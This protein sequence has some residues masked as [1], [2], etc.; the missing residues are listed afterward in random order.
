MLRWEDSVKRDV[1]KVGEEEDWK[2]KT[3]EGW[4]RQSDEEVTS[5]G[6]HLTSDKGKKRKRE[7]IGV[8]CP[9]SVIY[10]IPS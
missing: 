1:S 3:K 7:R 9:N 8:W 10:L 2:T 6:Q 4:K 5:C